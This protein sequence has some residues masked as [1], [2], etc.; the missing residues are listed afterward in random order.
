M[1]NKTS[2]SRVEWGVG[3]GRSPETGTV[4]EIPLAAAT[5]RWA[6]L[7]Y[8]FNRSSFLDLGGEDVDEERGSLEMSP[9]STTLVAAEEVMEEGVELLSLGL[10]GE[11]GVWES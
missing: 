2:S 7:L 6:V 3:L 4:V 10:R 11:S 5:V 8:F 1:A 9:V